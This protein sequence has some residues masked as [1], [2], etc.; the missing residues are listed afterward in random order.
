MPMS[1]QLRGKISR[2]H[3][4]ALL[5]ITPQSIANMNDI[6][7]DYD[8]VM[9]PGP[10]RERKTIVRSVRLGQALD[11]AAV[12]V[13]SKYPA[14]LKH[15]QYEDGCLAARIVQA[16]NRRI[17]ADELVR[18]K[19]GGINRRE[20]SRVLGVSHTN[21][22]SYKTVFDDYEDALG[23]RESVTDA[24]VPAMREW[25]RDQM[26]KGTLEVRD[27]KVSRTQFLIAFDLPKAGTVF[28][29]YPRVAELI[30]EFDAQVAESNYWPR[31]VAAKMDELK[32]ALQNDP[33]MNKDGLSLN[34]R[35]LEENLGL[36]RQALQFSPFRELIEQAEADLKSA[37]KNDPHITFL[38]GRIFKFAPLVACGWPEDYVR[39]IKHCFERVYAKHKKDDTKT[40]YAV[41]IDFMK[42]LAG[43]P[44]KSCTAIFD[45]AVNGRPSKSLASEFTIATQEWRDRLAADY[46]NVTSR[47]TKVGTS[48]TVIRHL[49]VDGI[50]PPFELALIGFREDNKTHLRSV[51]EVTEA[52]E[53][54]RSKPHVDDYL[55]FAT[56]MLKQAADSNEIEITSKDQGDFN[57]VLREELE[58]ED[59]TAADDPS[60]LIARI[61]DRRI[62][63]VKAAAVAVAKAGRADWET[64]KALIEQAQDLGDIFDD[65]TTK[66]VDGINEHQR[67]Q[68][69][70]RYFPS[71]E[72]TKEQGIANLLKVVV[73]RYDRVYPPKPQDSG[74]GA[75]FQKRALEYGGAV[76]LQSYLTPSQEAVS[77]ILTLYLIESGSNVSVGRSLNVDCIEATEEP[78]HSKVTGHKARAKGKPI[79][80][81]V[82]DRSEA[83]RGMRW[84]QEAF[85]LVPGIAP[86]DKDMLFLT[87]G[88]GD[89]F[90]VIEEWTFRSE[91]KRLVASIPELA[92]LPLTPNMLRPSI[93]LKTALEADGRTRLSMAL[94]QHGQQVHEGYVNK[95]PIRLLRDTQIRH[96]QDSV[97]TVVFAT[98]EDVHK[99]L[100]VDADGMARRVE[101]VMKTGLGTMCKNRMGRPGNEGAACKSIDCWNDCPQL[102]IIAVPR[103]IAILQLWQHSL[104]VVEGDWIRDQPERWEKVWLP[105][106][107]FVDAVEV[108][109]VQSY[110]PVWRAATE[111]ANSIKASANFQPM[112]LF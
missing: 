30:E 105:W 48:N 106:L 110:G 98:M 42:F 19:G 70:R 102:I 20:I 59:F 12:F 91:F 1:T 64:G 8:L 34:R 43:T 25:L 17:Q 3:F 76:K 87:L 99:L 21:M 14:L 86:G 41:I 111:I 104:R 109:M 44:S 103:E 69:L 94:G 29:R 24:K 97:E 67:R 54:K 75:F 88:W 39:R 50:L 61:L 51:A 55:A 2:V 73:D 32:A 77:A 78:H 22:Q 16:L 79:F 4:A 27:R 56:S 85:K 18:G 52:T 72:G 46:E 71:E 33:P 81:I 92:R 31:S 101:A 10:Q 96:F 82:E 35:Q 107:S 89:G 62:G 93:L 66:R 15:Q 100:G 49:S 26:A 7:N 60:K 47:N 74:V 23:Q 84:L 83:I 65:V 28:L 58:A 112:R 9:D 6:L 11:D 40:H 38:G 68:M 37:V 53:K 108:K 90:K 57:R 95:Y 45:G 63:L 80:A 13:V 36:S 5:G